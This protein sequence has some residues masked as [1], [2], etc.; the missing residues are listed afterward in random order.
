MTINSYPVYPVRRRPEFEGAW[1]G[2]AWKD[3]GI[4]DISHFRPES[5]DHRPQTQAKLMYGFEGIYGIFRVKDKFV[6]CVHRRHLDPVY[7]DSCVEFFIHPRSDCGYF[8][9]EFNCGG[10]LLA[11]YIKDPVRMQDGF[12]ECERFSKNDVRQVRIYHSQ[13]KMTDPEIREAVTWYIEFFIPYKLL[14]KYIGFLDISPGMI[15]KG[16]LYKCAD[17]SSHPHWAAWSPVDSL[18][19]HLPRCFG[20]LAFMPYRNDG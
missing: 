20:E 6:R 2:P 12:I 18:N 17:E 16:N 19:F 15:W 13:P 8:N 9:F 4:L 11:S 1:D 3:T 10:T 7:K 5:S 14:E